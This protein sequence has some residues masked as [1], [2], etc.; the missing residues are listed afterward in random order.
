MEIILQMA[1]VL[2]HVNND[3]YSKQK[4]YE[5]RSHNIN[6]LLYLLNKH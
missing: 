5:T 6:L 2:F 1:P 3:Q 4:A